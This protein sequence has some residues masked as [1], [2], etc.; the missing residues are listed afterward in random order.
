MTGRVEGIYGAYLIQF[1]SNQFIDGMS[2]AC[3]WF[4][5]NCQDVEEF[6][7]QVHAM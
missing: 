2:L 5:G 1:D 4:T 6:L 7:R 3:S